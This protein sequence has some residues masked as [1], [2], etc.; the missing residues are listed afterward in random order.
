MLR[1]P[2]ESCACACIFLARLS[3]AKVREFSQAF[4]MSYKRTNSKERFVLFN[5]FILK[6]QSIRSSNG[7][8]WV[9][10]VLKALE[11]FRLCSCH[12]RLNCF[13]WTQG[14]S[15]SFTRSYILWLLFRDKIDLKF[16]LL[17]S[18]KYVF[19]RLFSLPEVAYL[20]I[21]YKYSKCIL[22]RVYTN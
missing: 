19:L 2:F 1:V 14:I 5:V 4:A 16:R 13:P 6:Q 10:L 3:L 18:T 15:R 17:Y 8:P 9:R 20:F 21:F 12:L 22:R 11:F 7:K